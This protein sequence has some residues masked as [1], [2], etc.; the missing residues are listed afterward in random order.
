MA[1][2]VRIEHDTMGG[3]AVPANRLSII[4]Q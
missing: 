4:T 3:V 1:K 2:N